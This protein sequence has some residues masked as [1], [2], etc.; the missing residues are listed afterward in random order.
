PGLVDGTWAGLTACYVGPLIPALAVISVA[1]RPRDRFAT[2]IVLLGLLFLAAALG[3]ALPVRGWLYDLLPPTRYFRHA[4]V[5]RAHFLFALC[6]LA[7]LGARTLSGD[8]EAGGWRRLARACGALAVAAAVAF[9]AVL[10]AAASRAPGL[11]LAIAQ[12]GLAWLG[13]PALCAIAASSRGFRSIAPAVLVGAIA[14]DGVLSVV[15]SLPLMTESFEGF[16]VDPSRRNR[17][18]DLTARDLW[19]DPDPRSAVGNRHLGAK[20][21]TVESFNTLNNRF[22]TR[23][24]VGTAGWHNLPVSW[25]DD[26]VLRRAV[27]GAEPRTWFAA[28]VAELAPTESAFAAYVARADQLGAPPIVIHSR[29]AMVSAGAA[30]TGPDDA[31]ARIAQLPPARR[32]PVRVSAYLPERLA[33]SVDVPEPGWLLVTDRWARGWRA[34]VDARPTEVWGGSFLFRAIRLDAG[35]HEVEFRYAP[36]FH[37]WLLFASWGTLG[38]VIAARAFRAH[39]ANTR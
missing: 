22:H 34:S 9:A 31:A 25:S 15:S 12:F 11:P 5:F 29:D 32:V 6:V 26:A 3:D 23:S 27:S 19:R 21:P 37:P 16:R 14:V 10:A 35:H 18:L 7:P 38:F 39:R 33:F 2:A 36:S 20:I 13:L 17:T 1:R 24:G 30:H 28:E 4:A 8:L